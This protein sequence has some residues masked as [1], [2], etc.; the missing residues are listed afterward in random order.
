MLTLVWLMQ[1]ER[2]E[3]AMKALIDLQVRESGVCDLGPR[4]RAYIIKSAYVMFE[5]ICIM[6]GGS[7]PACQPCCTEA[8]A[9]GSH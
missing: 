4:P 6:G 9:S 5:C 8:L 3:S 2:P 7:G 1:F